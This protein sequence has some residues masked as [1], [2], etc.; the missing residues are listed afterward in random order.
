M[1]TICI[2]LGF[3]V[4]AKLL[5]AEVSPVAAALQPFVDQKEIAGA[6]T[7]IATKDQVLARDIIGFAD[8]TAK[9]QLRSDSLFWIAS[10]SKPITAA[11]FM[12]LV[13]EGRVKLDDPVT[14]YLPEFAPRAMIVTN[15]GATAALAPSSTI[16]LRQ[17]LCHESGLPFS[18]GIERPTLDRYPLAARVQSYALERLRFEPGT[19]SFYSNAGFNTI[20]RVIEVVTGQPFE[21]FLRVRLLE[22]LGMKDTTFWPDK[23]QLVRLAKAY[24]PNSSGTDLA[25]IQIDQL[26]Y[27][28]D[29]RTNRFPFAAGGLFSTADDLA[30]FAQ[31]MLNQGT[32]GHRRVLSAQSISE[33]I[34]NQRRPEDTNRYGLGF[35]LYDDGA[36]GHAGAYGSDLRI[37]PTRGL[38]AIWLTQLYG[39]LGRSKTTFDQLFAKMPA[40]VSVP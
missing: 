14:K 7:L 21:E 40:Q 22:P 8:V 5:P 17:L 18:S 12:I 37:D 29:D 23:A 4:L 25:E 3:C 39:Q 6:V 27:P 1:K 38:I 28:L 10:I 32:I 2:G 33:L 9:A 30:R 35:A 36:Y 24:A 26:H 19:D 34:R 31:M 15:D 13:D 11:A 20:A 16:T